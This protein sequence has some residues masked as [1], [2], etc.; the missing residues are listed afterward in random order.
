MT[1][2]QRLDAYMPT[3][4]CGPVAMKSFVS[5]I[6]NVLSNLNPNMKLNLNLKSRSCKRLVRRLGAEPSTSAADP[7][8]YVGCSKADLLRRNEKRI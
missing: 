7:L 5:R 6:V 8:Y 1:G 2:G 3:P 4:L